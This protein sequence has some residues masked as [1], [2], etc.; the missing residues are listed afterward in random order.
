LGRPFP[1]SQSATIAIAIRSPMGRAL[2]DF[3][4]HVKRLPNPQKLAN[5]M[6]AADQQNK[7]KKQPRR[8]TIVIGQ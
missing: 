5:G 1:E 3:G 2:S 4:T 7:P 8:T 6:Q